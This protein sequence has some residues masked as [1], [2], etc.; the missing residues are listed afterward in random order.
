MERRNWVVELG[1]DGQVTI[2]AE[3]LAELGLKPGD[4]LVVRAEEG[5]LRLLERGKA[6]ERLQARFQ[7]VFGRWEPGQPSMTDE[8][9]RE[10]R[11]EAAKEDAEDEAFRKAMEARRRAG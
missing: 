4:A 11:E 8:L 9:I 3:L 2:P 7:E 6:L 5:E 10:R 1:S